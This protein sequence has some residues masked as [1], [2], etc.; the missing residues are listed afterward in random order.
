M[1]VGHHVVDTYGGDARW[2]LA[3]V[4]ENPGLGERIVPG[5]PYLMAE[6][7]YGVQHEMA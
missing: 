6:A 3:Y 2:V 7:L 5:L 1:D 4:E